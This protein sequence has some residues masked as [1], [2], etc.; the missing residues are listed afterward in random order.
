MGRGACPASAK[1]ASRMRRFCM[2]GVSAQSGR[3][4]A[5]AADA[6]LTGNSM[7]PAPVAPTTVALR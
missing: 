6:W 2:S 1:A 4:A 5:S 7:L 3:A